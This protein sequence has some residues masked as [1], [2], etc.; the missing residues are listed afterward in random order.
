[1][2]G[3]V[4]V[5]RFVKFTLSIPRGYKLRF[6]SEHGVVNFTGDLRA[7]SRAAKRSFYSLEWN[8]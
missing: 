6:Y 2:D 1:V 8:Q 5:V 3:G 4:M 7:S